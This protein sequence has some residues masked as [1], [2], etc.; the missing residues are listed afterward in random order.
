[1][2]Y[3]RGG[4]DTVRLNDDD[5]LALIRLY[6]MDYNEKVSTPL[7]CLSVDSDSSTGTTTGLIAGLFLV[8][9]ALRMRALNLSFIIDR[10]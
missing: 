4:N 2:S 9:L 3:D 1:M 7:G 10:N 6:P 8:W 5:R